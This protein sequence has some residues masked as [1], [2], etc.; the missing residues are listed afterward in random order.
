M[1]KI[2]NTKPYLNLRF[3]FEKILTNQI[4]SCFKILSNEWENQRLQIMSARRLDLIGNTIR[5]TEDLIPLAYKA[6]R[7]CLKLLTGSTGKGDLY[8]K[9]NSD[10]NA[11][12]FND[13]QR[14]DVVITSGLLLEFSEAELMFVFGHELGH[15]LFE[16]SLIPA[17]EILSESENLKTHEA[18]LLLRWM[19][20]TEISADRVGLLCAG[21]LNG[22]V[23]ALFKTS[24]GLS[25]VE[26]KKILN[27]FQHQFNEL[28]EQKQS[29]LSNFDLLNTHPMFA[30]RF[31]ALEMAF[32]DVVAMRKNPSLF[33]LNSFLELDR[34]ITNTINSLEEPDLLF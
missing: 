26:P 23:S 31:K 8:V 25:N 29:S 33:S 17:E 16:H 15:V 30:V 34:H 1:E 22:A 2:N 27:S 13:S 20:A 6:F 19:R 32:L 10:F 14:F 28:K 5:V 11:S 21:D 9:Q 12:V 3:N 24:S 18:L 7:E 4:N